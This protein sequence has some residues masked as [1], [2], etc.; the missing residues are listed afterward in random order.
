[1]NRLGRTCHVRAA[2]NANGLAQH[3]LMPHKPGSRHWG[4]RADNLG[5]DAD[6]RIR[7]NALYRVTPITRGIRKSLVAWAAGPEYR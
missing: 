3:Q 1:M 4:Y 6:Q 5:Q 7:A 2:R